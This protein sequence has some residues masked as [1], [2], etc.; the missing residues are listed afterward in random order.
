MWTTRQ[1]RNLVI[2]V[3][4]RIGSF[5][6]LIRDRDTKF[7]AAFDSVFASTGIRI[8]KSPSRAPRANCYSERWV[9]TVRTEC[10][11]RT[12]IYGQAHLRAVPRATSA[13]TT[14]IVRTSPASSGR[15][16]MT[17]W[18]SCDWMRQYNAARSSAASSTSTT[19]QHIAEPLNLQVRRR[20]TIL[21]RYGPS[22]SPRTRTFLH[23]TGYLHR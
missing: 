20:T 4:D 22:A 10:T 14:G 17:R 16:T 6:F 2:D 9:R 19:G 11:D 13:T 18:P 1:A 21:K 8:V 15:P 23:P 7:T 12:L 3:G 5:R